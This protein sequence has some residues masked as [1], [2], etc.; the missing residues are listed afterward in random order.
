MLAIRRAKHGEQMEKRYYT[1][2]EVAQILNVSPAT[3]LRLIRSGRM[4]AIRV[5]ERIYRIPIPGFE[6]FQAGQVPQPF[7]PEVREGGMKPRIGRGEPL[8]TET[9]PE[10]AVTRR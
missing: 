5:S 10:I 1:P 3:V 8:P 2:A 9:P 7:M 6:R 4:P